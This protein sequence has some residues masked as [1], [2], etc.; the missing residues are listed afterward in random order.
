MKQQ[1]VD[2]E[3]PAGEVLCEGQAADER[4]KQAQGDHDD[5]RRAGSGDVARWDQR[6][7]RAHCADRP[8]WPS[9]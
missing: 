4:G 5:A 7:T 1:G 6:G 3:V 9:W 2:A 8:G